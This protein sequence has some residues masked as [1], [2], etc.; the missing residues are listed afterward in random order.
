MTAYL[1]VVDDNVVEVVV[2]P[3]V[4]VLDCGTIWNVGLCSTR[5]SDRLHV[6]SASA[7]VRHVLEKIICV[8]VLTYS[9]ASSCSRNE[10]VLSL[11]W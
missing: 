11:T 5:G 10:T 7:S 9:N 8:P 4:V 6:P 2:V 1:V 3:V